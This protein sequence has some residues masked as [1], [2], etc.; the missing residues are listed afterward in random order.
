MLRTKHGFHLVE[1]MNFKVYVPDPFTQ[2]LFIEWCHWCY[3]FVINTTVRLF[4]SR[5]RTDKL[6]LDSITGNP[7]SGSHKRSHFC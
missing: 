5:V 6:S 7:Y 4:L 1:H 3:S 2:P